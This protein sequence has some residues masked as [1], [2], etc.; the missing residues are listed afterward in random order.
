MRHIAKCNC[1]KLIT[2]TPRQ[3]QLE[4]N[5][6]KS[7]IKIF[8]EGTEKLWN[9]FFKPGLKI[10]SPIVS[11]GVRA[12]TKTPQ[13]GQVTSIILKSLTGGKLLSL[14]VMQ[15]HGLRLKLM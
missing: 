6:I 10:A 9:T 3:F 4:G 11:A 7:T 1:Q 13:A 14:T 8:F 12:K 2:F 5:R 15:G